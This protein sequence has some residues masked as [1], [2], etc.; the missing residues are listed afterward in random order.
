M[1]QL[2]E[3]IGALGLVLIIVLPLFA[4]RVS[5]SP[6][7]LSFLTPYIQDA[8]TPEDRS[9]VVKLDTT[10]LWWATAKHS[11]DVRAVGVKITRPDPDGRVIAA[12]PSLSVGF[13][14]YGF[15]QGLIA[16]QSLEVLD[17]RLR[18]VR[19]VDG[20]VRLDFSTPQGAGGAAL[21]LLALDELRA[22]LAAPPDPGRASGYLRRF[23]L[24]NA[25][26]TMEDQASGVI[27]PAVLD[28]MILRDKDGI[29]GRG[30]L[31]VTTAAG[32]LRLE[33]STRS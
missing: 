24:V 32:P 6:L 30:S 13:S 1:R 10:E 26:L 12:I 7:E 28:L 8:L 23:Q 9:Y 33:L 4:W 25:N 20:S 17:A 27:W 5:T 16:P 18:L 15:A 22:A 31:V 3:A 29:T 14:L 21:G 2:F 19:Q 11:L